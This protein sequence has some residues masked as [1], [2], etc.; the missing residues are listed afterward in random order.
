MIA[1][2]ITIGLA[3]TLVAFAIAGRRVAWLTS[4]IR[5]GQP[6]HGRWENAGKLLRTQLAEVAGQRKLLKWTVPGLVL[7][8][9]CAALDDGP[10]PDLP[11]PPTVAHYRPDTSLPLAG[12]PFV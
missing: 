7:M 2:R 5:A 6:E 1:A 8:S 9:G 12:T 3:M 10:M 4:L 11:V